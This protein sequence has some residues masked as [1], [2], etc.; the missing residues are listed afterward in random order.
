V[1]NYCLCLAGIR[2]GKHS[3]P[4]HTGTNASERTALP[5]IVISHRQPPPTTSDQRI[6][7]NSYV[8]RNADCSQQVLNIR[9]RKPS[10]FHISPSNDEDTEFL[11]YILCP[12]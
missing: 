12:N 1:T 9:D 11:Q 10:L 7:S 3:H 2:L 5:G 8:R 4:D 6:L